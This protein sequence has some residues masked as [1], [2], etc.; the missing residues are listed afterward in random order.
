MMSKD[1]LLTVIKSQLST[2]IKYSDD[3][4][5]ALN[6]ELSDSYYQKP[7]GNEEKDRSQVVTADHY[8]MVETDMTALA[9]VFLGPGDILKFTPFGKEDIEEAEQKTKYANYLIKDQR[10]SFTVLHGWMKEPGMAKVAAVKFFQE[11]QEKPEY[12]RYEGLSEDELTAK[13]K[14]EEGKDGVDRVEIDSKED[15]EDGTFTVKFRVIRK[16]KRITIANVPT[17]SLIISSGAACKDTAMIVG[18]ESTKTK[19]ELIAEGHSKEMVKALA[20]SSRNKVSESDRNKFQDQGGFDVKSGYHW[21]NDEVVVQDLYALIDYD[22]DGI[23]ER[24]HILKIGN[25]IIENEPYGIVPYALLSQILVPS[26]AIGRSR[27]EAVSKFQK[28]KT[29]IKRGMNDNIFEVIRPRIAYDD[30]DGSIDGGKVDLDELLLHR[31]S[32]TVATDG[33]P[34]TLLMPLESPYIGDKALQ[35]IQYLDAEKSQSVGQ[36]MSTQ[37]LTTDDFYQETATRF[38]GV[39]KAGAAKIKL[40]ARVYAE[41]GFRDLYEGVIWLAQHY[42][43]AETEIMV[44]GEELKVNPAD[45]KHNHYAQSEVGLAAGDT[46]EAIANVSAQINLQMTLLSQG[47]PIADQKKLYNSLEDLSKI[48]GRV[49]VSRYFNDPEKPQEQLLFQ[50]EQ[51]SQMVQQLQEQAQQ[52]PLAEAAM[53]EA[54]GKLVEAQGKLESENRRFIVESKQKS[55]EF[56]ATIALEMTKLKTKQT[57]LELKY[58]VDIPGEGIESPVD[59]LEIT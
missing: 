31:I 15:T 13:F 55:D 59:S 3:T 18:D 38:A 17:D 11:E 26:S 30:S 36:M 25:E 45:W 43:D 21:T 58:G 7:Y 24:R 53:V 19:G 56:A 22:E 54:R 5:Q 50:N 44:L 8:D 57:E 47:S 20:V 12:V 6:D 16:S 9:E 49:D 42:Q 4:F 32:G 1:E 34:H 46:D 29:A 27:G 41:T 48:M 52:N 40:V 2:T 39:E 37:G 10:E 14:V 51:L 35:V 28:E 33:S 23:P